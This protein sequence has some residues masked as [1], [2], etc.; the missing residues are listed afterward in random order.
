M[1]GEFKS[2][3]FEAILLTKRSQSKM[4]EIRLA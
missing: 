4:I 2:K 3:R 1:L